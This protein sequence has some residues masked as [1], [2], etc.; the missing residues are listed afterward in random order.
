MLD[1]RG[2]TI[3]VSILTNME[4]IIGVMTPLMM[5]EHFVDADDR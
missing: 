3:F 4:R 2:L 1:Y 5:R